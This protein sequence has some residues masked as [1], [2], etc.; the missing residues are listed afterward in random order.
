M[1]RPTEKPTVKI[2]GED[3]NAFAIIGKVKEALKKAGADEEYI[4][5]YQKDAMSKDY[6][7]LLMVTM[8][9]V[10]VN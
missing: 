8:D 6:S 4:L 5:R 2:L 1:I 3:G 9:Y 7:N 10:L